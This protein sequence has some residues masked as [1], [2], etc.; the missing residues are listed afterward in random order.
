MKGLFR[1]GKKKIKYWSRLTETNCYHPR[2]PGQQ[3]QQQ[4]KQQQKQQQQ[5]QQ[6]TKTVTA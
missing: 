5:Q 6:Q 3:Q 2:V 1:L 4:Q